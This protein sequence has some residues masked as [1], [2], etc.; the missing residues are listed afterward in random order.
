MPD[1]NF[2]LDPGLGETMRMPGSKGSKYD[3]GMGTAHSGSAAATAV[4][5]QN[6]DLM[7][8]MEH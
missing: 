7:M 5:K 6:Q 1:L 8:L 2:D 3:N 4:M